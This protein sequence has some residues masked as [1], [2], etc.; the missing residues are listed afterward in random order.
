[1][2]RRLSVGDR[3]AILLHLRRLT[4]GDRISCVLLCPACGEK[5]DLNLNTQ[6]LL[7]P[8]YPHESSFHEV[9]ICDADRCYDVVFRVPNGEDQEVL[10]GVATRSVESASE[11]A[12]RRCVARVSV[13]GEELATMPEIVQHQLP[14]LMAEFD[15][16][17]EVLLNLLCPEC[18]AG[19]ILPFDIADFFF[20][21]LAS[22][23]RDFY[24]GVHMLSL[25]YHWDEDTIL[26]LGRRK[27]QIYLE[28]LEDEME[29]SG[30]A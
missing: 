25:H 20:R 12:M 21:E 29:G 26:K 15:P 27:R 5:M 3:E 18:D 9:R 10:A 30:R 22:Q 6:E 24:R 16:Q 11:L 8:A 7:L 14:A 28:L 4:L 2:V 13:D 17:A 1:M 19:F 23:E